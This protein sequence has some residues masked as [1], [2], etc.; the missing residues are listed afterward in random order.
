MEAKAVYDALKILVSVL[1][2]ET[3]DAF[4]EKA[5]KHYDPDVRWLSH[6]IT[7]ENIGGLETDV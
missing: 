4:M 6:R 5:S 7:Y 2:K 3:R 1:P